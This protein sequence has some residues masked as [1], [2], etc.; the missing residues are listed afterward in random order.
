MRNRGLALTLSE[1]VLVQRRALLLRAVVDP[2]GCDGC[3]SCAAICPAEAIAVAS[4]ARVHPDKCI[5]CGQCVTSCAR[6]AIRLASFHLS[7]QVPP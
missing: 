3:A 2:S 6:A 7:A 1:A 5:A 4:V